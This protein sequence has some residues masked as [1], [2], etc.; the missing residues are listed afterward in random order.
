MIPVLKGSWLPQ[1][2]LHNEGRALQRE[3]CVNF[4]FK[5]IYFILN[6]FIMG[7]CVHGQAHEG[8]WTTFGNLLY[9][10]TVCV[11][12]NK[13]RPSSSVTRAFTHGLK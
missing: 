8:Q 3:R 4:F 7:G 13:L 5:F 10:F 2:V 12:G 9:P 11:L 1:P 6:L